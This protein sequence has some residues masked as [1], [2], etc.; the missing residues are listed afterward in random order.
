MFI[1]CFH[2]L[3]SNEFYKSFIQL[4]DGHV[5]LSIIIF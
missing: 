5:E 2:Q 4:A 3:L 1:K